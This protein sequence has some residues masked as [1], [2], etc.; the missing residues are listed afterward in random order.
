MKNQHPA[1]NVSSSI[2]KRF[3]PIF[4]ILLKNRENLIFEMSEIITKFNPER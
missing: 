4:N 3:V 2:R 1:Y